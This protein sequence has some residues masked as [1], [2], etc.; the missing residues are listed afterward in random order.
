MDY[1]IY[2]CTENKD[3]EYL[4]L[5]SGLGGHASFWQPQVDFFSKYFHVFVY[6]QEGCLAH[7]ELLKKDY[8]I[9]DLA[10]QLFYLLQEAGVEKFHFLGHALG[11]FIGAE[12]ARII[13]YTDLS[14]QSLTVLN[15]WYS[16]DVHT[17]KCFQTRIALLKNSGIQA[18]VM[19]QAL[20]LYPP[21]WISKNIEWLKQQEKKQIENFLPAYNMFIRLQAV[22]EY[23]FNDETIQALKKIPINLIANKDDFL[24]PYQQ[25]EAL[26]QALPHA[27]LHLEDKGGHAATITETEVMNSV[28]LSMIQSVKDKSILASHVA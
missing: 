5:S 9:E 24:V 6:D 1:Q 3:A 8:A 18:F 21:A 20:F 28:I 15:G 23:Q 4:V 22:I 11:G 7:S 19:A 25:S 14:I 10:L 17:F 13:R 16:L 2:Q 26:V 27:N 12:L